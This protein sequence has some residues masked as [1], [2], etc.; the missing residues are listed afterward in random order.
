MLCVCV[1]VCVCVFQRPAFW[2]REE[3]RVTLKKQMEDIQEIITLTSGNT[4]SG[5][6]NC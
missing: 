3:G 5:I 1:C 4:Q 6:K 2:R